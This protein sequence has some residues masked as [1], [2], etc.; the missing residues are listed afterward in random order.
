MSWQSC[1]HILCQDFLRSSSS[2]EDTSALF[3]NILI[4]LFSFFRVAVEIQACFCLLSEAASALTRYI[5][6]AAIRVG[7]I[8]VQACLCAQW[9]ALINAGE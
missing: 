6:Q 3:L 8:E 7:N 2:R 9:E 5:I 4:E 1:I